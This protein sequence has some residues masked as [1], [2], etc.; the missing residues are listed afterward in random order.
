MSEHT[1]DAPMGETSMVLQ[2]ECEIVISRTFAAPARI[3]FDAWTRADLVARW[4][5]PRSLGVSIVECTADVRVGGTYRY[6]IRQGEHEPMGFSGRYLEI[7]RPARI[8]YTH[9][10]EPMAHLGEAVVTVTFDEREGRT[11]LR[12]VERYPSV[13]VRDGVIASG[14]EAG[15]RDTMN[16]LDALVRS[17]T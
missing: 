14:M 9:A 17:L 6:V 15:M 16:Q 10:F 1:K 4:W 11:V 8:V 12:S 2:G 7:D 3:V 5:A 13:E